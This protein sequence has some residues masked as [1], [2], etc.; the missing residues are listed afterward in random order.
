MA[1]ILLSLQAPSWN[2]HDGLV[3]PSHCG[4]M[5]TNGVG[6]LSGETSVIAL[7]C[8]LRV[9]SA[10]LTSLS[11]SALDSKMDERK[12]GIFHFSQ[13]VLGLVEMLSIWQEC[14]PQEG[15]CYLFWHLPGLPNSCHPL[16]VLGGG[17]AF[18]LQMRNRGSEKARDLPRLQAGQMSGILLGKGVVFIASSLPSGHTEQPVNL[19][20]LQTLTLCRPRL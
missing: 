16:R 13:W 6:V 9:L 3:H 1:C 2:Y 20:S 12:N 4:R 14:E 11:T 10:W 7:F 15:L 8:F 19:H 18:P 17:V 5:T